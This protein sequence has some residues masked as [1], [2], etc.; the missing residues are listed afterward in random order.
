MSVFMKIVAGSVG[1]AALASAA[2]AAA[3]Y[4][5]YSPYNNAPYGNAYGYHS[6]MA[7]MAT[8]QCTSAVQQRLSYRTGTTGI[9]GAILG[10]GPSYGRVLNVTDVSPRRNGLRV[11]GLATSGRAYASSPYGYGAYGATGYNYQP[12]LRFSCTVDMNGYVRN[13]DINRR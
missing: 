10:A 6:N 11:S 8:Q 9:L 3:Q 5:G 4:Y 7:N 13:V 1:V 12:D 2:P